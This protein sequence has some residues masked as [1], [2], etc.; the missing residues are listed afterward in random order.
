MNVRNLLINLLVTHACIMPG[1]I[2][3]PNPVVLLDSAETNVGIRCS[4]LIAIDRALSYRILFFTQKHVL[5]VFR[6]RLE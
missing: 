5:I 2:E 1:A 3:L 6:T 4:I